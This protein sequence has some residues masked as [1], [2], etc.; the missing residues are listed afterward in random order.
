[1]HI[2]NVSIPD[3]ATLPKKIIVIALREPPPRTVISARPRRNGEKKNTQTNKGSAYKPLSAIEVHVRL[4]RFQ[5]S[6]F[7]SPIFPQAD[8]YDTL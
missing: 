3:F 7:P 6:K 8:R 4:L 1:M 5:K 2:E